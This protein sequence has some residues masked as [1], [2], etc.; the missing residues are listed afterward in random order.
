MK[1]YSKVN[2]LLEE[3]K[4]NYQNGNLKIKI[5]RNSGKEEIKEFDEYMY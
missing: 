3:M 1:Y 4:T 2:N 5:T